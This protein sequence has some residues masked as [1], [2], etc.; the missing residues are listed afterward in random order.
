M[1]TRNYLA[2]KPKSID[3]LL[4]SGHPLKTSILK[5]CLSNPKS[6]FP[7]LFYDKTIYFGSYRHEIKSIYVVQVLA[8]QQP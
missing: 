4:D 1:R 7:P 5:V 8:F 3:F 2:D 6:D